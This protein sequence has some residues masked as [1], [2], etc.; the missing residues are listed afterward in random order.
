[1]RHPIDR[2][3]LHDGDTMLVIKKLNE[4]VGKIPKVPNFQQSRKVW[5]AIIKKQFFLNEF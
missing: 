1:M 4:K 5:Q 3:Y 2:H